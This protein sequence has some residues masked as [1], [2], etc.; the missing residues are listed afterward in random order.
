MS[1]ALSMVAAITAGP[2]TGDKL[3]TNPLM[4]GV[5]AVGICTLPV[6]IFRR[7]ARPDK[8]AL[9][10]S[11]GRANSVGP[12]DIILALVA[13]M[14]PPLL[15]L[16]IAGGRPDYRLS[17][18]AA[19]AGQLACGVAVILIAARAFRHGLRRGLGLSLRRWKSDTVRGL[20]GYLTIIPISYGLYWA[21]GAIWPRGPQ[22]V[23]YLLTLL[24][25][26]P[27]GWKVL[28]LIS[29][30]VLAPIV[31]EL[32]FRGLLQSMFRRQ[33]SSPWLAILVTSAIFAG[34][35]TGQPKNIPALAALGIALG[36][37]YE[38]CGRLYPSM[39][40][41]AL[42]NAVNIAVFLY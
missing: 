27:F 5:L 17:L 16:S 8:F 22:D 14:G 6:W 18:P 36:Y 10:R 1:N 19:V 23:P 26:V 34:I 35:H 29:A 9:R 38:R 32:F 2:N 37:N 13:Y 12:A 24:G 21:V 7:I 11:P 42:F 40:L 28:I 31:E 15:V 25:E 20:V 4:M 30:V 39:L 33:L 3:L 41:H